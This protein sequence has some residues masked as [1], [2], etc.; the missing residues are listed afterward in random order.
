MPHVAPFVSLFPPDSRGW[1]TMKGLTTA[2]LERACRIFLE[3]AYPQGTDTIPP[4]KNNFVAIDVAQPVESV[5]APPV[6]QPMLRR[7]GGLRG[8]A[9][10]LGSEKHPH[11]KLQIVDHDAGCVFS[12]DTHD[13]FSLDPAHPDAA[14]WTELQTA[15]RRLKEEIER[16]WEEAGLVTFNGLLRRELARKV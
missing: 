7:D 4:P 10:R 6:C 16:A 12:V 1:L 11:F 5:L 9:L 14:R 3:R 8:Y 15:N 13:G 2:L